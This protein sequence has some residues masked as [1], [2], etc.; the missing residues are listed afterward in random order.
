MKRF[1]ATA[2]VAAVTF[3]ALGETSERPS[4]AELIRRAAKGPCLLLSEARLATVREKLRTDS[5]AQDW[6]RRLKATCDRQLDEPFDIPSRGGQWQAWYNCRVC[7]AGLKTVSPTNHVCRKCGERHTGFPYDDVPLTAKHLAA[8]QR[9]RSFG[10]AYLISGDGRYAAKAKE[11]LLAY[12]RLYPG[13]PLHNKG[14]R[15]DDPKNPNREKPAKALCEVLWECE[16]FIPALQGYD[17]ISRTLTEAEREDIRAHLIR[18]FVSVSKLENARIH[19]HQCWH[20]SGF[21]QCALV[22]GDEKLLDEA[23]N[24]RWGLHAQFREGILPDGEWFEGAW[25]YH[26]YVFRALNSF[27]MALDNLGYA[28]DPRYKAMYLAPLAHVTSTWQLPARH[29]SVREAFAPGAKA[30]HYEYAFA[31]WNDPLFGRWLSGRRRNTEQYALY[32]RPLAEKA[33]FDWASDPHAETGF[34]VL[35]SRTAD[36]VGDDVPGNYVGIDYGDHGGWHGHYDKMSVVLYARR[37]LVAEDPGSIGYGHPKQF[38][39]FRTTL[40]HNT[41][42]VDNMHQAAATGRFLAF[43]NLANGAAIAVDAG[44]IAP[45]VRARRAIALSGDLVF[46]LVWAESEEE[47]DWEWCFHSRGELST[48]G[49]GRPLTFPKP[50]QPYKQGRPHDTEGSNA[51]WWVKSPTERAHGGA[52]SATWRQKDF[53]LNAFQ[54]CGRG[55]LRTGRGETTPLPETFGLVTSRTRGKSAT[56]ATVMTLDGRKAVAVGEPFADARGGRGLSAVVDGVRY[57]FSFWPEGKG[58]R[59]ELTAEKTSP[60]R[61][62]P[63][64][65]VARAKRGPCL[66]VTEDML[67][68]I[69]EKVVADPDAHHWYVNFLGHLE[70]VL[71]KPV[72]IPPR[73][74]QWTLWMSCKKCGGRID[75]RGPTR[76]VCRKCGEAYSGWPYDDCYLAGIHGRNHADA[77]DLAIAYLLTGEAKYARRVK[78]VLLGYA[79]A[80]GGYAWHQRNGPER[81]GRGSAA[82]VC[83]Q[84]LDEARWLIDLLAAYDAVSRTLTEEERRA[85]CERLLRPSVETVLSECAMWSNHEVWHLAAYGLAGLVLGD[86]RLVDQALHS[87]YGALNQLR[88]GI[89]EDGTWYEGALHYHFFTM[90][91]FVPLFRAFRNLGYEVPTDFARMYASP[92]GQLAPDGQLPPVNDSWPKFFRPGDEAALYEIGYAWFGDPI[93]GWWVSQK[94]RRTMEYALW[95]RPVGEETRRQAPPPLVSRLYG[96][97]GLAVLRTQTPGRTRTGIV[98]DNCLMM[99]FGPHGEWHG[100]PD[101]LNVFFWLRGRP[102]AEDIGC[103]DYGNN[104]HWGWYK[105]TLAHNELRVDNLNQRHSTG[106]LVA[107]VTNANAAAVAA[108]CS[109]SRPKTSRWDGPAYDGVDMLRATA[110]VGDVVLDYLSGDSAT[111][112]DYEWCFHARGELTPPAGLDLRPMTGLPPRYAM[113]SYG[114]QTVIEGS[115]SWSWTENPAMAPHAGTWHATWKQPE[116]AL[117]VW[118]KSAAGLFETGLGRAQPTTEKVALAVNKVR[119]R[120]AAFATVM[121]AD[122]EAKVEVDEIIDGPDGTRGF[123]ATV[124]GRKLTL[125]V[126]RRGGSGSGEVVLTGADF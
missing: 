7:G 73:G 15:V 19:N 36:D 113:K 44:G 16:W 20:L 12:A 25:G 2:A 28:P 32:G 3:L 22:L 29:D 95:G 103:I 124:N 68:A 17:A 93:C 65:L 58:G 8:T 13:L 76:H 9:I 104:M 1:F 89:L 23:L 126:N 62:S 60:A 92:L 43:T 117:G 35:R 94:P 125:T 123:S 85:V 31:W 56:F 80:Y 6:W 10:L 114:G 52:W 63:A 55:V 71:A 115:E 50:V 96:P 90:M 75:S 48:D 59:L 121:C 66:L 21:G 77:R 5:D 46:D 47:H 118:Q 110:L 53:E 33:T 99:D 72:D 102:V 61:P 67:P 87:H 38:G 79:A 42:L 39:W 88:N 11:G 69:R 111:E 57:A 82:R 14:G 81:P 91:G 70:N 97:S 122:P 98:P 40:A 37:R 119:G 54:R 86:E 64:E 109:G 27:V 18:E 120:R 74:G 116:L 106:E 49:E 84:V 108:F 83:A 100:H 45:G 41:L 26:F 105:S 30:V 34:G 24:G 107:F 112:H 78:D 51:W 4:A 101:K